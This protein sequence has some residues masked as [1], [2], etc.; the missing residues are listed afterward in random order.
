MCVCNVCGASFHHAYVRWYLL[1]VISVYPIL[2]YR[3]HATISSGLPY[4]VVDKVVE[5]LERSKIGLCRTV[6]QNCVSQEYFRMSRKESV[7]VCVV[8]AGFSYPN[9]C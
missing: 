5:F 6:C 9:L 1:E 2:T 8:R 4:C 3:N 7:C